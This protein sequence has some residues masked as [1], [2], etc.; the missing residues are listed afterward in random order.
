MKLY[1]IIELSWDGHN[2][3]PDRIRTFS[4]EQARNAMCDKIRQYTSYMKGDID[5]LVFENEPDKE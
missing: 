3:T 2:Y 5:F 4:T 1:H